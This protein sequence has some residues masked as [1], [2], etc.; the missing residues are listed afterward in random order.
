ML[1]LEGNAVAHE[2]YAHSLGILEREMNMILHYLGSIGTQAALIAGFVFVLY[3]EEVRHPA[4]R[5]TPR[6]RS[7]QR[8]HECHAR[9]WI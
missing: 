2:A 8:S 6:P 9:R 1:A 5:S 7:A 4:R 3:T